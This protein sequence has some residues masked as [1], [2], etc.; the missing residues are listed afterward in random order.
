MTILQLLF[1]IFIFACLLFCVVGIIV[2][3]YLENKKLFG[4]LKEDE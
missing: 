4:N 2:I 3:I 1:T